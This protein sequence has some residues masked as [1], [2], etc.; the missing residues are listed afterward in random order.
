MKLGPEAT[1]ER[2]TAALTRALAL[3]DQISRDPESERSLVLTQKRHAHEFEAVLAFADLLESG[4]VEDI[5]AFLAT[6]YGRP[7]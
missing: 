2:M 7:A 1:F 3:H 6:T 4:A 5:Q